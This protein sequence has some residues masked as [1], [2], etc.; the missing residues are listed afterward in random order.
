MSRNILSIAS[1]RAMP[2]NDHGRP[3]LPNVLYPFD[4]SASAVVLS[5]PPMTDQTENLVLEI[6]RRLQADMSDIKVTLRDVQHRLT[7]VETRLAGV[8]RNLSDHYAAYAGQ[9]LRID[10]IEE[11]LG[12]VER[13]L[14]I[15]D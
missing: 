6:L 1:L 8:E 2:R 4:S 12:R 9:G 13:R 5:S 11:R 3:A 15:T 14:E 10:R 7:L